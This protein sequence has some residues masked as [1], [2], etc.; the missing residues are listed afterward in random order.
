M[1]NILRHSDIYLKTFSQFIFQISKF[2]VELW[3]DCNLCLFEPHTMQFNLFINQFAWLFITQE[4]KRYNNNLFTEHTYRNF[5]LFI[6]HSKRVKGASGPKE[7][8]EYRY[9]LLT[10]KNNFHKIWIFYNAMA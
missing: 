6:L 10:F 2:F 1:F 7:S 9:L 3:I 5:Y 8:C 4:I